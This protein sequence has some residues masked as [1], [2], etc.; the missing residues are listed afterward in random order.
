[1]SNVNAFCT[2]P[3][4]CT[5]GGGGRT[6]PDPRSWTR[7]VSIASALRR[8]TPAS[9]SGQGSQKRTRQYVGLMTPCRRKTAE[10]KKQL[11]MAMI[12]TVT[13]Q[14]S[15]FPILGSRTALATTI[16]I[17]PSAAR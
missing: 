7:L 16:R 4:A 6:G 17:T 2:S 8:T 3:G 13:N 15:A 11:T 12:N 5:G 1:M 10:T 14:P 9:A